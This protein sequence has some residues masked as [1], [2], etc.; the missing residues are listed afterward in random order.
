MAV[1]AIG[2]T[3]IFPV[4]LVTPVVDIPAFDRIMKL[5]AV[6]RLTVAGP[7]ANAEIDPVRPSTS[8]TANTATIEPLLN[9]FIFFIYWLIRYFCVNYLDF[10][11]AVQLHGL[12]H[13]SYRII[14]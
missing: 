11:I 14:L 7:A 12:L 3:P 2:L 9:F 13:K 1:P 10:N 4:I 6:P 5:P 8:E